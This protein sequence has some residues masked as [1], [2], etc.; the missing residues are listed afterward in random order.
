MRVVPPRADTLGLFR[1]REKSTLAPVTCLFR[2]GLESEEEPELEL[3]G[4]SRT[5]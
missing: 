1:A 5:G 2:K 3:E 4:S